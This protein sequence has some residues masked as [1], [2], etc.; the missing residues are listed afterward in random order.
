MRALIADD[1]VTNRL[2]MHRMLSAHGECDQVANGREVLQAFELAW[3]DA[4][5][6]DLICLDIMMPEMDG[7]DV[8]RAI[9][10]LEA[11][12]GLPEHR[13]VRV[14][15][16]TA[17]EDRHTILEAFRNQCEAYLVKPVTRELLLQNLRKLGLLKAA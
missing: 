4:R 7:Q 17:L 14:I 12:R 6:Y 16:T 10:G 9:R 11:Q 15:M 1:D 2:V 8:L 5:P 3:K 13:G